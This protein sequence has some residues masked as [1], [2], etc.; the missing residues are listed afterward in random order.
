MKIINMQGHIL[1]CIPGFVLVDK[2]LYLMPWNKNQVHPKYRRVEISNL[3]ASDNFWEACRG[4]E[5]SDRIDKGMVTYS[6]MGNPVVL[7]EK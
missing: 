2:N 6:R 3:A 7:T 4:I 5:F 1:P